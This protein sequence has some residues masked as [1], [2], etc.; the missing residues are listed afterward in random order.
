MNKKQRGVLVKGDFFRE[1]RERKQL[2]REDLAV[3]AGLSRGVVT[4]AEAGGPI[5]IDSLQRLA[6]KLGTTYENLRRLRTRT[7]TITLEPPPDTL[8]NDALKQDPEFRKVLAHVLQALANLK[9]A[10]ELAGIS[11]GS[12]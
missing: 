3:A 9:H 10:I 1:L 11:D 12:I 2:T 4:R 6:A 5:G 8:T 7:G